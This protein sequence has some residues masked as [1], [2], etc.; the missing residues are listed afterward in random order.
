[1]RDLAPAIVWQRLVVE[2]AVTV[3]ITAAIVEHRTEIGSLAQ[4]RVL[5]G[6]AFDPEPDVPTRDSSGATDIAFQGL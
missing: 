3:P 5:T 1:M 4:V 2:G 6:K